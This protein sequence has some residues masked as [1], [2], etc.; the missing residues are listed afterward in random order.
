M[1]E[2]VGLVLLGVILSLFAYFIKRWIEK[3]P[4]MEVLEKSQKLLDINR[5]M[6]EQ[7]VSHTE[8]QH[9]E[10]IL[11]GK[12]LAIELHRAEA[13]T[14]AKPLLRNE[15]DTF[16]TQAEMYQQAREN[17]ETS[18]R[19]MYATLDELRSKLAPKERQALDKAQMAWESY[20]VEQAESVAIGY[21]DGSICH[22]IYMSELESTTTDRASRLQAELDELRRAKEQ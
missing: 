1:V 18:Q 6:K 13:E 7:G 12:K 11:T 19:K 9:L 8:L 15:D 3:K 10:A 17:F 16:K 2:K 21:K 20:S 5:Q 14:E 4:A 22:L